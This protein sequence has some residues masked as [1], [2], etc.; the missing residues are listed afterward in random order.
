M[1]TA[2]FQN[3]VD[4]KLLHKDLFL[5]IQPWKTL[6]EKQLSFTNK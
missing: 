1:T 6:L 2:K 3:L 4:V 5:K